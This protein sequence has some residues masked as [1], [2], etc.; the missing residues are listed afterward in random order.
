MS[1]IQY[2]SD[3]KNTP[4]KIISPEELALRQRITQL[5]KKYGILALAWIG[6]GGIITAQKISD[7]K[8]ENMQNQ[9][10]Y[11][12]ANAGLALGTPQKNYIPLYSAAN[13]DSTQENVVPNLGMMMDILPDQSECTVKGSTMMIPGFHRCPEGKG[14]ESYSGTL[15]I[16]LPDGSR[17]SLDVRS[18]G[19]DSGKVGLSPG[20]DDSAIQKFNAWITENFSNTNSPTQDEYVSAIEKWRSSKGGETEKQHFY[21]LV[22]SSYYNYLNP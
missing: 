18:A 5:A 13:N 6:L 3:R 12:A 17:I 21:E 15:L 19:S 16:N 8:T 14:K 1:T 22:F 20:Q 9:A 7:H 10:A 11:A 4:S 2:P